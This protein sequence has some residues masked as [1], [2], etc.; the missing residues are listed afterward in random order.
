MA[1][2]A[3]AKNPL[4]RRN[5]AQHEPAS[6]DIAPRKSDQTW[7][8]QDMNQKQEKVLRALARIGWAWYINKRRKRC[9]SRCDVQ[10]GAGTVGKMLNRLGFQV[11]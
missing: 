10:R 7:Y 8:R 4:R 5:G 1:T 3:R 11:I 9:G 6:R 2:T